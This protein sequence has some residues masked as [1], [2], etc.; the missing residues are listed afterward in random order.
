MARC[1]KTLMNGPCGGTQ[2][3]K[4]E[5]DD[6]VDCVWARIVERAS[7]LGRLEE[8][9]AVEPPRDWSAGRHGGQRSLKRDD[10]GLDR[11][12]LEEFSDL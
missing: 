11:L 9:E 10:L 2:D 4:C 7:H 1:A 12:C 6:N 5:V 3:G 8:L